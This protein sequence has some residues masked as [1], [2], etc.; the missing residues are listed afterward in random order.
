MKKIKLTLSVCLALLTCALMFTAC[1]NGNAQQTPSS[2]P[3]Y[4]EE[5]LEQMFNQA[6]AY[7]ANA[8]FDK[9]FEL[10]EILYENKYPD[11]G[12]PSLSLDEA[13]ETRKG[14]YTRDAIVCRMY[15]YA[16]DSLKSILK[17]PNSLVIHKISMKVDSSN[18][19]KINITIDYGAANSFGGMV[20]N[21][22]EYSSTL[23]SSDRDKIYESLKD[24]MDENGATSE[25]SARYL[26]GNHNIYEQSQYDAIVA[27]TATY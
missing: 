27:G 9:A 6:N 22:Y 25:D 4:S 8:N 14:R 21:D 11:K 15:S 26:K 23:S 7:E 20:R 1:D 13:F 5:E 12:F 24:W 3:E 17:D 19:Y 10:Y 2:T 16:V 18:S